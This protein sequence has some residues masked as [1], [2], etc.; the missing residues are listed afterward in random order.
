MALYA[1]DGTWNEDR[2]GTQ[3]DTNVFKFYQAYGRQEGDEQERDETKD[4][5]NLYIPGIG[6]RFGWAG[7]AIGGAFGIGGRW[8]ISQAMKRLEQNA[9]KGDMVVDVVGFSRGA[10]TAVDFVNRVSEKH[11]A[12][13]PVRFL[14]LW[15]CVA[16]FGV[17]G[18]KIN[19]GW[20][21]D[22]PTTVDTCYHALALDEGRLNF[23]VERLSTPPRGND[24][25]A[26]GRLFEV[27]FRG[28]HSDVGGGNGNAGLSSITLHWMLRTAQR[29][30]VP[31]PLGEI[32]RHARAM[33]P[34]APVHKATLDTG[35]RRRTVR[36]NDVV[37]FTVSWRPDHN[38]P[39]SN[40]PVVD[41]SLSEIGRFQGASA[42]AAF[43][44][45]GAIGPTVPHL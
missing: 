3:G 22:I 11:G 8:R 1:F 32:D 10:A 25:N 37:H 36:W 2:D 21:L 43:A 41:D 5:R 33:Q 45:P 39:P 29:C 20:H 30:G 24:A 19:I 35:V 31:I 16:S 28:V 4:D 18:N 42:A 6:T 23:P 17:P 14:G 44:G 38:N 15:D 13:L 12:R 7:K 40:V 27:W 34:G 9:D 26:P